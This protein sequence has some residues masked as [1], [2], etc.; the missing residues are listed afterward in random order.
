M[1][2]WRHLAD[3]LRAD[4]AAALIGVRAAKGS[5]PRDPG[6]QMVMRPDGAF[7]GTIG[8]GQLEMRMLS[9]ARAML[10][11]GRGAARLIDQALGPDLGQCCGGRVTILIETFD[12][13]DLAEAEAW[14]AREADGVFSLSCRLVEGRVVREVAPG[15]EDPQG[16]Q[17]TYGENRTPLLL[18]GAGH[19]GRA[20]V[21][22]LAPL[23]FAV[24]WFD[25]RSDAFPGHSPQ[26]ATTLL[27]TEPEAVIA[28]A[29][30]DSF[31]LVMTHDHPLDM[32]ITAA[33]LRRDFPYLGLIGSA[34]KRARFE[35]RFR[36]AGLPADRIA[37]LLCPIGLTGIRDK[38][39]A[40]IAASVAAQLL[41]QR[42]GATFLQALSPPVPASDKSA[43]DRS[44][45]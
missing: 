20:L 38:D 13:R 17:E 8:G 34:S 45:Q 28:S 14:A 4:G 44:H 35:R 24:R 15:A 23:P 30:P 6:A 31:V 5:V 12:K 27:L 9:L 41:Q 2:V 16:W 22:A 11:E 21:L 32:A 39:P 37:A 18:F 26:N 10:R 40:V 25:S 7:H 33:A 19:V 1:K 29:P 36:E 3:S 42:E 43:H